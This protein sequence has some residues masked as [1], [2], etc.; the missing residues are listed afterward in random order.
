M[1]A[2]SSSQWAAVD[3]FTEPLTVIYEDGDIELTAS[4]YLSPGSSI[5]V[6]LPSVYSPFEDQEKYAREIAGDHLSACFSHVFTDLFLP[7][8]GSSYNQVPVGA[9][10]ELLSRIKHETG[11]FVYL[12]GH[13]SGNRVT[14]QIANHGLRNGQSETLSGLIMFSPN[15]TAKAPEAGEE[16]Q[17]MALIQ[18]KTVPLY[19]FQPSYSP[20]HWHLDKLI[21]HIQKSGTKLVFKRLPDVRDGYAFRQDRT[22][23]EQSL[24]NRAAEL[25]KDA[26]IQ[27]QHD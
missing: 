6:F 5:I 20:H 18:E 22:E 16:Q 23:K 24:R 17:Y 19:I 4:C 26:I 13:G 21:S 10:L 9:M 11:K 2:Y 7:V 14:Y 1:L 15:L 3:T 12:V 25:F 8:K 27:L